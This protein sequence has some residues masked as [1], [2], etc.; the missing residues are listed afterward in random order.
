MMRQVPQWGKDMTSSLAFAPCSHSLFQPPLFTLA[1]RFNLH[2]TPQPSPPT[3]HL[4]PFAS[5]PLPPACH[6]SLPFSQYPPANSTSTRVSMRRGEHEDVN[7]PNKPWTGSAS[8]ERVQ[9]APEQA[10][11]APEQAQPVTNKPNEQRRDKWAQRGMNEPNE[12]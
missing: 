2:P 5:R 7:G 6:P 12:G 4:S 1:R 3:L 9:R 10:Q 11:Q 8:I